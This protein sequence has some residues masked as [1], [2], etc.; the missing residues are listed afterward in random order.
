MLELNAT[1][2]VAHRLR[3][4]LSHPRF[5]VEQGKDAL[6]GSKAQLKLTPE[7]RNARQRIPEQADT[8]QEEKPIPCRDAAIKHIQSAK[9]NDDDGTYVRY[10]DE[11][12][13]DAIID[14][15]RPHIDLVRLLVHLFELVIHVLLLAEVLGYR[16][17]TDQL[18]DTIE[19]H[20]S[21]GFPSQFRSLLKRRFKS[22]LKNCRKNLYS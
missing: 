22:L 8:L 18:M 17:A 14:K 5:S 4:H 2:Q 9:V 7:R 16:D 11:D 1:G 3:I 10:K 13:E 12:G 15:A 21:C 19:H 20:C 6:A